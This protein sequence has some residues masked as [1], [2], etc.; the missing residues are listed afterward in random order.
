MTPVRELRRRAYY[1]LYGVDALSRKT[2]SPGMRVLDVGCSDGRESEVLSPLSVHG[3]DTYRALEAARAAGRR[4]PVTQA[5][6]R[7]VPFADRSFD[8]VVALDVVE[9][10]EKA[11]ALRALG[12]IERVSRGVVVI[13][14]PRGFLLQLGIAG[15]PRQEHRCDFDAGELRDLGFGVSG[16]GRPAVL[17]GQYR[18]FRGGL[19]GRVAK[20]MCRSGAKRRPSVAFALLARKDLARAS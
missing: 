4:S 10:F 6:V 7:D 18:A 1:Q 2:I 16:L 20:A 15:E 17:R 3:V 19:L 8:V 11:D 9:H 14:T 12:E 5:D 13:V